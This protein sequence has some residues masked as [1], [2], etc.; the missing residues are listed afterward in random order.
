MNEQLKARIRDDLERA[1]K[2]YAEAKEIL[3]RLRLTGEDVR[4]LEAKARA[5]EAK[6]ARFKAAF[7][8]D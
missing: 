7:L 4:E 6:I 5:A 2:E 1:E 3:D 8:S